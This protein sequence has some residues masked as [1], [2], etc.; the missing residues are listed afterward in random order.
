MTAFFN[1]PT[2]SLY[3]HVILMRDWFGSPINLS[4]SLKKISGKISSGI[5]GMRASNHPKFYF[6]DAGIFSALRPSGALDRPAEKDGPAL[7][8]LVAQH[9]R[10][11]GED[12]PEAE[13][14]LLYRGKETLKQHGITIM[15]CE[16]FLMSPALP[17][18]PTL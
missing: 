10:A 5:S 15:P 18:K 17:P 12:Y 6:F 11:F 16:N 13:K 3:I 7:E 9:L 4:C 1:N 8:G 14:I 2:G